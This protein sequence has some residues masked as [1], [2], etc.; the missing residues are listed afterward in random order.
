MQTTEIRGM[1]I[2]KL[3]LGTVQLGIPYGIANKS[4]LPDMNARLEIIQEALDGGVNTLDTAAAYGESEK[5]IG[6]FNRNRKS[7]EVPRIVTKV[8]GIPSGMSD[9]EIFDYVVHSVDRSRDL[10]CVD[11]VPIVLLHSF[12]EWENGGKAAI[13][14]LQHLKDTGKISL[15]GIS[16]Y[17]TDDMEKVLD[18]PIYEAVQVPMS[19][20]DQRLIRTG[21]L[22]K[23]QERQIIVFVRSIYLQG[24]V[25]LNP[26]ELKGNLI[27]AKPYLQKL[28]SICERENKKV[29]EIALAF[30]RDLKAVTGLVLGCETKSQ[31]R[32]NVELFDT[33]PLNDSLVEEIKDCFSD[34]PD[35]VTDPRTWAK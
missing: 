23:F 19:L 1:N 31:I 32:Q 4:G 15:A 33:P 14:A 28:H 8:S 29:A 12:E 21:A 3:V 20:L 11:T 30:I 10:L 17:G 35:E 34:L 6:T 5:V 26:D 13:K 27:K 25:F 22:E 9:K 7:A 24:L 16:L 2:S 18:Q